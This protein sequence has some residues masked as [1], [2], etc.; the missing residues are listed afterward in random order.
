[1]Y[2]RTTGVACPAAMMREYAAPGANGI[3]TEARFRRRNAVRFFNSQ[4]VELGSDGGA[5]R[6]PIQVNH[7]PGMGATLVLKGAIVVCWQM[8]KIRASPVRYLGNFPKSDVPPCIANVLG[9][10]ALYFGTADRAKRGSAVAPCGGA[11]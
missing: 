9:A 1:M 11:T 10:V 6:K 4:V 3:A 8:L 2:G 7:N 5:H